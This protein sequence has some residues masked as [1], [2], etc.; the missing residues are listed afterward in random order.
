MYI[1]VWR[2]LMRAFGG[3]GQAWGKLARTGGVH[4]GDERGHDERGHDEPALEGHAH[5]EEPELS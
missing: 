3:A 5:I 2:A 1:V 4:M